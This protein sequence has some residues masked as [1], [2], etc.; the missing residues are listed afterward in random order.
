MRFHMALAN[1][2]VLSMM[3]RAAITVYIYT[4]DDDQNFA[5]DVKAGQVVTPAIPQAIEANK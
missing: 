2:R 1:Q 4:N 5:Y 3:R